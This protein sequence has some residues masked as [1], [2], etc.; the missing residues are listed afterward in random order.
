MSIIQSVILGAVQGA[1]EF[2]PVSSSGHLALLGNFFGIT[3]VSVFF[4]IMLHVGTLAAVI[5]A[6][7]KEIIAILTHPVKN[8]LG[9]LIIATLPAI[10]I[11]L[12]AGKVFPAVFSDLLDG[13]YLAFGFFAT[14]GVLVA[15]EI[16]AARRERTRK[17]IDLP[18]A[19][20]MGF[21]QAAAIAPGLSRSGATISGG[22]FAGVQREQAA[23]FAFLMSIPAI[24]GG[25]AFGVMDIVDTG[26]GDADIPTIVAGTAV[27]AV[28]GYF[29]IMFMLKLISKHRL[30]GFAVYTAVIGTIILAESLMYGNVFP[31]P[32]I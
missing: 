11:T 13:K 25:L 2:L 29:A 23:K 4:S 21:M 24:V 15:C 19:L 6:L 17:S 32:F 18:Q 22:L 31:N 26:L 28:C 7:R 5:I 8:K 3:N 16:A 30:Y 1:T 27:A 9:M 14:T 10:I 20:V 12:A